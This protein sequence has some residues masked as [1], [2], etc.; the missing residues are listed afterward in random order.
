MTAA[1]QEWVDDLR[2]LVDDQWDQKHVV[3]SNDVDGLLSAAL[4][5][6]LTNARLVGF[7]TNWCLVLFDGASADDARD[8][9]WVD[10]D[11]LGN[12]RCVGNHI[13]HARAASASATSDDRPLDVLPNRNEYS[14]NLNERYGQTAGASFRSTS[15]ERGKKDKFPF[16]TVIV[17]LFCCLV[18]PSP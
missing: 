7:Y 13:I 6:H 15:L 10:L 16:S 12:V 17:R 1:G 8:A 11:V 3:T 14:V 2:T 9:L 18:Y 5:C 4:V